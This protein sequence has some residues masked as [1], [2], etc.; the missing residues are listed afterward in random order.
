M[1][2][3]KVVDG[4]VSIIMPSW[5]T[6]KYIAETIQSVIDQTYTNWELLIVDDCSSDNTDEIVTS[7]KDDRIKYYHN[8]KNLGAALTRNKA[9]REAQG[10]W[11]AFLDSD[12]L[13]MPEKLE[14]QIG[15]MKKNNYTLSFTEYEKIDEKSRPLNIY[16]SGPEKVNKHK[17]YNYDYIGQLTMMYS[18]KEFGLIQIKDIKKNNDYAIRLQLYKKNGTCAY[19]L[20]ENLAKYRVRKVSISHDKFRKKFKS[21]YDL[22]HLCDE[23][24]VVVSMWYACWNMFYG[25]LK[26]KK[27]EINK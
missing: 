3:K 17:M 11:I 7:F 1:Q 24:S 14:H 15:F 23:K 26:K 12:D 9:L 21:H 16:V 13:W 20:K 4:L 25:I 2:N 5:N 19:L 27:Y 10:E 6:E 8:K 18:A 22:F